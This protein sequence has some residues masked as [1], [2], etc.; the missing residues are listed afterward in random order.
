MIF[1][2]GRGIIVTIADRAYLFQFRFMV[3]VYQPIH[4]FIDFISFIIEKLL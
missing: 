2:V 4:F 3:F 1:Y